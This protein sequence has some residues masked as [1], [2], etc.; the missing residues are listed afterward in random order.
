M[1]AGDLPPG[2]PFSFAE[3]V[4][5]RQ[6]TKPGQPVDTIREQFQP[7]FFFLVNFLRAAAIWTNAK[8][9]VL[10][11]ERARAHTHTRAILRQNCG[12]RPLSRTKREHATKAS[13][14][15]KTRPTIVSY[16]FQP[17]AKQVIGPPAISGLFAQSVENKKNKK[18]LPVV[19][20][21]S[22]S[23]LSRRGKIKR[24]PP[25]LWALIVATN[26]PQIA[27]YTLRGLIF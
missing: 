27:L 24:P 6:R 19:H 2:Y 14:S 1:T 20:L 17:S 7:R 3:A 16:T 4:T 18:T 26:R 22:L 10:H 13:K 21:V 12:V 25:P 11:L 8:E 23:S 5:A 15:K 9:R